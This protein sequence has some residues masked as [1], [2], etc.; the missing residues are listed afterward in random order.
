[1]TRTEIEIEEMIAALK[2]DPELENWIEER[3]QRMHRWRLDAEALI[4]TVASLPR[5]DLPAIRIMVEAATR[6]PRIPPALLAELLE[7]ERRAHKLT[8][9]LN[10]TGRTLREVKT[11]N[12]E[13][14]ADETPAPAAK[15]KRYCEN[16]G[17]P[18]C[19]EPRE[20]SDEEEEE[21]D[22]LSREA[23]D[24]AMA[25]EAEKSASSAACPFCGNRE[26]NEYS[27]DAHGVICGSCTANGPFV[28][29]EEIAELAWRHWNALTRTDDAATTRQPCPFCG[30]REG[31]DYSGDEESV[32]CGKC[33]A[34]GPYIGDDEISELAWSKWNARPAAKEPHQ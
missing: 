19:G 27:G 31:N 26:H 3:A 1:M 34:N 12:G 28:S 20:V 15:A 11:M 25:F 13:A 17:L 9:L 32:E 18:H 29:D 8:L 10:R 6:D 2:T 33:G 5:P 30:N 21:N 7:H 4:E 14:M 24:K 16:C 23:T 22:R